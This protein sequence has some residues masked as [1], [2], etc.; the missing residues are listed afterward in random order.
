MGKEFT[1]KVLHLSGQ[2]TY[3]E[4]DHISAMSPR[5]ELSQVDV[6]CIR[7]QGILGEH[8][9]D[10]LGGMKISVRNQR[11]P[12]QTVLYGPVLDQ[13]ALLG[14]LTTLYDM[15]FELKSVEHRSSA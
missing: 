14:I 9:S 6:Y 13:A 8:W 10:Y 11:S 2:R 4:K 5:P 7:I 1:E 15:G 3:S 12:P